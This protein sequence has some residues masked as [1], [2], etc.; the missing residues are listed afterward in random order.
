MRGIKGRTR[1]TRYLLAAAATAALA[2]CALAACGGDD[3]EDGPVTVYS[4]REEEL[5]A[6]L[7]ERYEEETGNEL[8]VRYGDTA[9]LAATITEEGDASPADVFF[10]QDAGALGALEREELLAEIPGES[11]DRVDERYRSEE[12]RWIGTSGRA[13]VV[14][15]NSEELDE[16]DLPDSILDFTDPEWKGRIGWAPTNGSFQAFVTAMRLTEGEEATEEWLRGIADN[17]PVVFDGN[18]EV[19]D[20]I[21]SGEIDVGFINHY[22]V[23]QAIAEEGPDYPVRVYHPPAGD[24]GSLINVAGAGILESSGRQEAAAEFIEFLLSDESQAYFSEE[25]KEYPLVEG[26]PADPA[27]TP[28]EQIEQPDVTLGQLEDLEGTLELLQ[29]SG[30]L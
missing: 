4:G 25:T 14:A 11:L 5:V 21:A 18:E 19:R 10:G 13:R 7:F 6:P 28:L 30:A 24:V 16:S 29:R 27:V 12:D 17:D 8:E 1:R 9:E 22:Y 3:D 20:A 26:I 23:A 15:Y 2:A